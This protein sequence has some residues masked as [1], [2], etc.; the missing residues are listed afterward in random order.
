MSLA[1]TLSPQRI[2]AQ[3]EAEFASLCPVGGGSQQLF[4]SEMHGMLYTV[5]VMLG[6][7]CIVSAVGQVLKCV[8]AKKKGEEDEADP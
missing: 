5:G 7:G 2:S 1:N 8:G 6:L 3:A 4:M